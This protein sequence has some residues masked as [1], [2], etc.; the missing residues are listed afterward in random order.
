MRL[1]W[2]TTIC[3]LTIPLAAQT[4]RETD[5]IRRTNGQV[6]RRVEVVSETIQEVKYNRRGKEQTL[7]ASEVSDIEW[8]EAGEAYQRGVF[9]A[10]RG[11]FAAAANL[12]Q[13]TA[14]K[15]EREA[16]KAHASFRAAEALY[17]A[18]TT[19]T[20]KAPLAARALGA[21]L[22]ANPSHRR[23]PTGRHLL[24]KAW[25][26]ADSAE[27]AMNAFQ[28]LEQDAGSLNLGGGWIARAK[29]GQAEAL[30]HKADFGTARQA[31]VTASATLGTVDAGKDPEV[32]AL[33]IAAKIGEGECYVA[34]KRFRDAQ[35]FFAGLRDRAG[36]D[37]P[38][39]AVA[40][41]CG[42][43]QAAFE[44]ALAKKDM[45]AVRDAQ[46]RFARVS[47]TDITDGD[48]TAKALYYLGRTLLALGREGEGKD[49]GTRADAM[50]RSVIGQYP[51]SR[52]V[53]PARQALK[54]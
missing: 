7:A 35:R 29:F 30:V 52:W 43:A 24:G 6:L 46:L 5:T 2:A 37:R 8:G 54:K 26:L 9:A 42:E 25:L 14:E 21:W 20:S 34:E 19:E 36:R 22:A 13:E 33:L 44:Q 51:K 41:A 47:A 17:L 31:Y 50:F 27:E 48:A 16:L 40:A 15:S 38:G 49:F 53:V 45:R 3:M 10:D 11:D 32:P 12:F 23:A 18:A 4:E 28:K 1:I 39:L